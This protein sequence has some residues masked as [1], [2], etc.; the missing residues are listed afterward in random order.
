MDP[1]AHLSSHL[2][3]IHTPTEET[4]NQWIMPEIIPSSP[5]AFYAFY[6]LYRQFYDV[7]KLAYCGYYTPTIVLVP[8]H[9]RYHRGQA[10]VI[11][12]LEK[13]SA[14]QGPPCSRNS[15]FRRGRQL[16]LTWVHWDVRQAANYLG[17]RTVLADSRF[18]GLSV[19]R[20]PSHRAEGSQ[21]QLQCSK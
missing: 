14:Q 15:R 4:N 21:V 7:P 3:Y 6:Q 2:N 5:F 18:P 9:L 20:D 16:C 8:R 13:E 11:H 1:E 17:H 19:S 10:F 12:H